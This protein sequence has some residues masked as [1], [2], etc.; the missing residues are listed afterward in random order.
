MPTG[1]PLGTF[2]DPAHRARAWHWLSIVVGLARAE[3]V[4]HLDRLN[5]ALSNGLAP[6]PRFDQIR[7]DGYDP[8]NVTAKRKLSLLEHVAGKR[9]FKS[10]KA[11]Y[12]HKFWKYLE[13]WAP[14]WPE[15]AAWLTTQLREHG[16]VRYTPEDEAHGID[17]GLLRGPDANDPLKF[18][19]H[20]PLNL[21][22]NRFATL[23][24][25][26]LLIML[27]REA[28]DAGHPDRDDRLQG[29]LHTAALLFA[30]QYKYRDEVLDTWEMLIG[31]RMVAWHP[32]IEPTESELMDAE[33][34]LTEGERIFL[35]PRPAAKTRRPKVGTRSERRWRR[36]VWV[37][38][39]CL[40]LRRGKRTPA[41]EYRDACSTFEWL[42]ANR[43]TIREYKARAINGLVPGK[44]K[45]EP[46]DLPPL[47]MPEA[48]YDSRRRPSATEEKERVFGDKL[49]YDVIPVTTTRS[50]CSGK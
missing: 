40:H 4:R 36:R 21:D 12:E 38:A 9:R 44:K 16:I 33:R 1:R 45:V 22:S 49:L 47:C 2:G 31:S 37:H 20:P 42:I 26:L 41:F 43:M 29:A 25:L 30:K 6:K 34:A 15:R 50:S 46:D 48:L 18:G 39:C 14:V 8:G 27:C 23:D 28:Q 13:E 17:L 35:D 11:I 32:R 7:Q 10:T 24:G 5:S 19:G 3:R